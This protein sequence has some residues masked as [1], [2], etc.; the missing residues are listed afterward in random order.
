FWNL[1]NNAVKFTP[2]DG[3]IDIL[4]ADDKHGRFEFKITDSGIGIDPDK[5]QSL[6]EPFE[7]ADPSIT[8]RFGGL[9]L[10]LAISKYIVDLHEGNI[11][12]ESRGRSYGA[13][14]KVNF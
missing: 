1:I 6:F 11:A 14:F 2:R 8:R 9:G 5:I 13:T 3:K 7:Q 12:V 4:T 10:G